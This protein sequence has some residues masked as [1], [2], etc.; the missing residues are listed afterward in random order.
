MVI[1]K[2]EM[3]VEMKLEMIL[4]D[5]KTSNQEKKVGRKKKEE[6]NVLSDSKTKEES[7]EGMNDLIV[8]KR[9]K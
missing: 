6:L 7:K 5:D 3:K 8:N 9:K 2:E 4:L 1:I